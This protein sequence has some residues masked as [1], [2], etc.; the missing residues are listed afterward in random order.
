MIAATE[1][2]EEEEQKKTKTTTADKV[3]VKIRE[4]TCS[5]CGEATR[6]FATMVA[7]IVDD[8]SGSIREEL[9]YLCAEDYEWYKKCHRAGVSTAESY[10]RSLLR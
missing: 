2:E 7:P 6:L 10:E 4:E 9:I 8:E 3:T 5:K 1:E